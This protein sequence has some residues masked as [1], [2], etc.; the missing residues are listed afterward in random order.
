MI[1]FF[2]HP[3]CLLSVCL[4]AWV[5]PTAVQA[6]EEK[7]TEKTAKPASEEAKDGKP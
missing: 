1:K 3:A 2:R 5:E 4:L 6:E 7:A